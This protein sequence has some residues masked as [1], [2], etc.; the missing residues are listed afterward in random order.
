VPTFGELQHRKGSPNWDFVEGGVLTSS[1]LARFLRVLP[2]RIPGKIA[3]LFRTVSGKPPYGFPLDDFDQRT[4]LETGGKVKI[5]K[6]DSVNGNYV[7]AQGYTPVQPEALS[8]ALRALPIDLSTYTFVDLGCGKGRALFIASAHGM[9]RA[10]GVEISASLVRVARENAAIWKYG[11]R[12][13]IVCA[14]AS[15][16]EWPPENV[17]VFLYNPFDSVIL[18]KVLENLHSSFRA[19]PRD[20]WL[21]YCS[22]IHAQ[23]V[24]E[25][26]WL[27]EKARVG[28]SLIYRAMI[29]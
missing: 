28:P 17:V 1:E 6:L 22:P 10:I 16:W 5:Y 4:G 18:T 3:S 23:C 20:A 9:A 2:R 13:E 29:Q 7:H 26:T 25:Q 15:E 27:Q 24:A 14:D 8:E 12:I 11:S 19:K 21:I